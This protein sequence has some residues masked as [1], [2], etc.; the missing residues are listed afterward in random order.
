MLRIGSRAILGLLVISVIAG[1]FTFTV[2]LIFIDGFV[3]STA[4]VRVLSEFGFIGK[5]GFDKL[6]VSLLF[7]TLKLSLLLNLLIGTYLAI[8]LAIA[9]IFSGFLSLNLIR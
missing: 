6:D 8:E 4:E 3:N 5:F 1:G 9:R 2:G 7:L